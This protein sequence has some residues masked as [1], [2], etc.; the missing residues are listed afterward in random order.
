MGTSLRVLIVED[1]EDDALLCLKELRSGY[2][3]IAH[4]RVDTA[5]AMGAALDQQTWD[6]IIADYSMPHFS[7]LAALRL[8]LERDLDL[9]FILVSGVV[10]EE[11][12][13][14]AMKAG[15][16]DYISKGHLSR[17]VPAVQRELREAQVRRER[18]RAEVEVLALNRELEQRVE[19]RTA[20]LQ[21]A[22]RDLQRQIADRKRAEEERAS[23]SAVVAR[24][25]ATLAA[26]MI[27][28]SDGVFVLDREH[29]IRYCNARAAD[30][31]GLNSDQ[32]IGESIE[33]V[34]SRAVDSTADPAAARIRWQSLLRQPDSS[35]R[36]EISIAKPRRRDLDI[37]VFPVADTI[38]LS[39][40]ILI[41]DVTAA[42]ALT[43]LEE[44]ER[45]AMDLHDGVIQSLY[46]VMLQMGAHERKL[47]QDAASTREM[48][49]Q[50]REEM[51]GIIQEIRND[52]FRLRGEPIGLYAG[53]EG[54]ARELRRVVAVR[55]EFQTE[56]DD[57]VDHAAVD[58]ILRVA[59]EATSN[60]IRHAGASEVAMKLAKVDDNLVLTV[61]DN[62]L[63]F[64]SA[65]AEVRPGRPSG[66]QGL[67]NMAARATMLGGRLLVVSA[68]GQGSEIRLE[69]PVRTDRQGRKGRRGER[70][71]REA[72]PS[73]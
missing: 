47:G 27:S 46:A 9:P 64:N 60:V 38:G 69:V 63:G 22:V 66:G 29:R 3:S 54:V 45:I 30:Y 65:T 13:V 14:A 21:E 5:E 32:I 4:R 72:A 7:G 52:I 61:R 53:L 56:I 2:E 62:G 11:D 19:E 20:Q 43:L 1:S 8:M 28:M 12:A 26:V 58:M 71:P 17:L 50:T 18:Q 41:Q 51:H 57:F 55:T 42:K 39:L 15:A 36:V 25:Q 23:L 48:L 31:F 44:R 6:I 73:R 24:E 40:G 34:V 10:G 70:S 68:P 59:R 49:R 37:S 35:P 33:T 67:S 16:Q